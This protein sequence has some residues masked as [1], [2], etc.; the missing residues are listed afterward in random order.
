MATRQRFTQGIRFKC[1]D[2]DGLV[3]FMREYDVNSASA[4]LMGFIGV[5][6]LAD[7]DVPGHYLVIAEFAEV[8]GD[9]TPE[10]EAKRNEQRNEVEGWWPRFMALMDGE[11]EWSHYDE[12][13]R[14]GITGNLRT[15]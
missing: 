3:Q 11:P 4:D 1:S 8:D 10:E 13:Y 6:V 12:L 15:G 14:T 5:R 2:P 7:R 9:L